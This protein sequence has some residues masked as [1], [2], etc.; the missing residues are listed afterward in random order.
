M[1]GSLARGIVQKFIPLSL[2]RYANST[3]DIPDDLNRPLREIKCQDGVVGELFPQ[4]VGVLFSYD[5]RPRHLITFREDINPPPDNKLLKLLNE[6]RLRPL[7]KHSE[8]LNRFLTFIGTSPPV[9]SHIPPKKM[10]M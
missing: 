5:G 4:S 8:N 3:I 9:Q 2:A 1:S 6:Y 7:P 10:V